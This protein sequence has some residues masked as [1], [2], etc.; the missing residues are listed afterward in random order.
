MYA[1]RSYYVNNIYYDLPALVHSAAEIFKIVYLHLNGLNIINNESVFI[2]CKF[3]IFNLF[4]Y[5]LLHNFT[6]PQNSADIFPQSC[7]HFIDLLCCLS[8]LFSKLP[9]L[10]SYNGEPLTGFSGPG[11]YNFV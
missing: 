11:S 8:R 1:I 7:Q 6:L 5:S 2:F 9:N 3:N 10:I 4:I